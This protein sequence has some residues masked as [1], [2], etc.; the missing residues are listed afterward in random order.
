MNLIAGDADFVL[1]ARL[2][3]EYEL[4]EAHKVGVELDVQPVALDAFV[5]LVHVENP[6]DN[7]EL[8]TVRRIYTGEITNWGE[9]SGG[10]VMGFGIHAYQRNQQSGSQELMNALVMQGTP[11]AD[12]PEMMILLGMTGPINTIGGIP[13]NMY[14]PGDSLGIGYSVYY[15]A[16]Y[17]YPHE[18]IKLISIEGVF[19]TPDSIASRNYPLTT[20]VYAVIREGMPQNSNAVLLRDWLLTEQ[21]QAVVEQSGYVPLAP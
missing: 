19:P 21:G 2:P 16:T 15:Y 8:D 17:I 9:A 13:S 5:F 11:M 1:V 20:E 7:L 12:F 18:R 10:Q 6:V 3:S 14:L 4:Q